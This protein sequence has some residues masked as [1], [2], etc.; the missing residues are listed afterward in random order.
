[1]CRKPSAPRLK[2]DDIAFT[3]WLSRDRALHVRLNTF[4]KYF[5][6]HDLPSAARGLFSSHRLNSPFDKY[7]SLKI[8]LFLGNR[9]KVSALES[10]NAQHQTSGTS[11]SGS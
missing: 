1:M 6:G 2:I 3:E 4:V 5:L 9:T 11:F 8:E 10:L 7:N